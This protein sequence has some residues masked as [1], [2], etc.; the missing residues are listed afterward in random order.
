PFGV[1]LVAVQRMLTSRAPS[2]SSVRPGLPEA[3]DHIVDRLLAS[4][5]RDR[6]ASAR[7]LLRDIQ[8]AS[9]GAGTVADPA[10][11]LSVPHPE[12]DPLDGLVV[13]RAAE[14]EALRAVLERLAEGAAP[15]AVVAV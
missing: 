1:G 6:P 5:A 10:A 12:G 7:Q 2:L 15:R 9:A 4:D 8:R 3:W 14:R 11:D 13:G